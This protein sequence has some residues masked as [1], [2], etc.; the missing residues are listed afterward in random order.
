MKKNIFL[1]ALLLTT[2]ISSA[3]FSG[4]KNTIFHALTLET[5]LGRSDTGDVISSIEFE[6]WIGSDDH[7]LFLKGEVEHEKSSTESGEIWALYSRNIHNFWDAQIGIRNDT[8]PEQVSYFVAGLE[9]LAPQFFETALH[10]FISEDGDFSARIHIE[11]ELL[12]TQKL[13]LE[14]SL[15]ANIYAQD[16]PTLDVSSGLSDVEIGLQMRYESTKKFAPYIEVKF[17][18]KLGGTANIVEHQGK[19]KDTMMGLI[20][21]RLL[22]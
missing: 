3:S 15:E 4:E 12:I 14:P 10:T 22:F 20:G 11:N 2:G 6:G 1:I 8:Q 9:G 18:K 21:L 5:A 13:V 16:I 19:E 17:E 7:K